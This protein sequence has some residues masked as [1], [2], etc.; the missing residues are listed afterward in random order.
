MLLGEV[1]EKVPG[2]QKA[3][4]GRKKGIWMEILP[5]SKVV[6]ITG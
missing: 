5:R 3:G 1:A 4:V 2:F 6:M